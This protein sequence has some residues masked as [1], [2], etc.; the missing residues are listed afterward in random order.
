[1]VVI[2]KLF[3]RIGLWIF[4]PQV[5]IRNKSL[6]VKQGPLLVVAN[7]PD[8]FL[9][10]VILGAYYPRKM[11]FL[12]RGDVFRKPLFGF[13]LRSIGMIPIHR[14]REGREHLH[15]N[16][17]TFDAS[18]DVLAKGGGILIFIEGICLLTHELQPYKKGATR[19][20]EAAQLRGVQPMIHVIGIA[21]NDFKA[22]GKVVEIH[23]EEFEQAPA[24][25]HAKH[26]LDFNAAVFEQMKRLIHVPTKRIRIKKSLF[27][28]LNLPYYRLVQRVVD[29]KTKDTVFYD[30]VLFAALLFTYPLYLLILG[31]GLWLAGLPIWYIAFFILMLPFGIKIQMK[32]T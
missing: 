4:A 12:A 27:Y 10:A 8:S 25:E 26:R 2:L 1:M 3:V 29:Q 28:Y 11:H 23:V 24:L 31:T 13:L 32:S 14:A 22:F 6:L 18:V 16:A 17:G 30:S 20:L 7:H 19:I 15:L 5:H 21:Y 9:D